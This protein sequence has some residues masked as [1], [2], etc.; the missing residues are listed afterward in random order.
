LGHI[1]ETINGQIIYSNGTSK[2]KN[3][4]NEKR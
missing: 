2:E 1:K 3:L 4:K